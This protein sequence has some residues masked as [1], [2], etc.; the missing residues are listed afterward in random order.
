[1]PACPSNQQLR[2]YARSDTPTKEYEVIEAHLAT[3]RR[4]AKLVAELAESDAMLS[5]L[6]SAER[7]RAKH[8]LAMK[9]LQNQLSS[10]LDT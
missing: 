5:D 4:C 10:T 3:C 8:R 9:K 7:E 1:M 2:D 6:R